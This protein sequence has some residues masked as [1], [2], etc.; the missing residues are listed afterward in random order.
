MIEVGDFIR[1]KS[2]YIGT[3]ENINDYREPSMK[4]AIE[5]KFGDL[6]FIGE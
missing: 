6:V 3:V 2:G 1:T 5:L 4:Y